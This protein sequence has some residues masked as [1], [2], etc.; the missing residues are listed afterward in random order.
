MEKKLE[1][2]ATKLAEKEIQIPEKEIRHRDYTGEDLRWWFEKGFL[3]AAGVER[4]ISVEEDGNPGRITNCYWVSDGYG[5][6]ANV[7]WNGENWWYPGEFAFS[8]VTHYKVYYPPNPSDLSRY[9]ALLT[10]N[11]KQP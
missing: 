3:L 7:V 1:D 2:I 9:E 6:L 10:D 8:K 5:V 4:W 11:T